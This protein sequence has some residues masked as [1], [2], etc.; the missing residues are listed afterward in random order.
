HFH[1]FFATW[2]FTWGTLQALIWNLRIAHG[3]RLTSPSWLVLYAVSILE[4]EAWHLQHDN[5]MVYEET[6]LIVQSFWIHD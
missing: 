5:N 3:P 6:I 1:W 2:F 4:L